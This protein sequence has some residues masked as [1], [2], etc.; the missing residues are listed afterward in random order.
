MGMKC[1]HALQSPNDAPCDLRRGRFDLTRRRLPPDVSE[2]DG[3]AFANLGIELAPTSGMASGDESMQD[4]DRSRAVDQ[5]RDSRGVFAGEQ[6]PHGPCCCVGQDEPVGGGGDAVEPLGAH[7]PD[8]LRQA[9]YAGETGPEPSEQ[10]RNHGV[11][12][13]R[14]RM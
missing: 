2:S 8:N 13:S 10:L 4:H 6:R 12:S 1:P 7:R 3:R 9:D 11:T 14:A 5:S